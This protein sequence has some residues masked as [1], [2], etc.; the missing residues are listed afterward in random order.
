MDEEKKKE[1]LKKLY[2]ESRKY[3]GIFFLI[4]LLILFFPLV[5]YSSFSCNSS[6]G[7]SLFYFLIII[8]LGNLILSYLIQFLHYKNELK[9]STES[10]FKNEK[11][12]GNL[13]KTQQS[14]VIRCSAGI[15][16][17][18]FYT[19]FFA[20][21]LWGIIAGY[22]LMKGLSLWE[23]A[24]KDE[25]AKGLSTASLRI[26]VVLSLIIALFASQ[27]LFNYLQHRGFNPVNKI[28]IHNY[29][30]F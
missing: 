4:L 16:E 29:Y 27:Y 13:Y 1:E 26:A 20:I 3:S 17:M 5:L 15:L 24:K 12:L 11:Y 21:G 19:I 2:S 9:F 18:A 23:P 25:E 14:C 28:F 8:L 30:V 10:L 22:L 7:F 6:T